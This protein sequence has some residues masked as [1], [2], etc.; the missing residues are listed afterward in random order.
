MASE[1]LP[2]F[3]H[4]NFPQVFTR[5]IDSELR[6]VDRVLGSCC[7]SNRWASCQQKA[8]ICDMETGYG[9]C[10]MHFGQEVELG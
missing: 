7:F 9:Y 6:R 2:V 5:A 1:T 8:A 3:S 10:L 4:P